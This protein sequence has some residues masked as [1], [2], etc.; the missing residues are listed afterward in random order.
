MGN[1]NLWAFPM[2]IDQ[3]NI[4]LMKWR[5]MQYWSCIHEDSRSHSTAA[6]ADPGALWWRWNA[7]GPQFASCNRLTSAGPFR[8]FMLIVKNER[9]LMLQAGNWFNCSELKV[10]INASPLHREKIVCLIRIFFVNLYTVSEKIES[11]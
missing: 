4:N 3:G 5:G 1:L 7:H 9:N 6:S 11:I 8:F 2:P 10:R